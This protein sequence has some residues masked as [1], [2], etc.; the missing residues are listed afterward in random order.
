MK[1]WYEEPLNVKR[2]IVNKANLAKDGNDNVSV[3]TLKKICE[4]HGRQYD[5]SLYTLVVR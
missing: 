2:E 5:N 4:S 1:M 3:E